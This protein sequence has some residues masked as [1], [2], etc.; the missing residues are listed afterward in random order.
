MVEKNG[1]EE[2]LVFE[3]IEKYN[4]FWFFLMKRYPLK[5]E[6]DL[7]KDFRMAPEDAWELLEIVSNRF[8][9]NFKEIPFNKYFPESSKEK[10]IPLTILKLVNSA[11]NKKWIDDTIN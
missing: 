9:I 11:K 3:I 2:R 6:T 8:N 1:E 5:L 10:P 7:N 4:G